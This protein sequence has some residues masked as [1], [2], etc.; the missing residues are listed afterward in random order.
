[1]DVIEILI[2]CSLSVLLAL[3]GL[4]CIFAPTDPYNDAFR[5][6]AVGGAI[7]GLLAKPLIWGE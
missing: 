5:L 7:I 1:M 4:Q 3:L 2:V 6:C